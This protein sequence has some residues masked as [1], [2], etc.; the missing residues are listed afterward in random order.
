MIDN[1]VVTLKE[2]VANQSKEK[3]KDAAKICYHTIEETPGEEGSFT[4]KRNL[5]VVCRSKDIAQQGTITPGSFGA[6]GSFR[7]WMT[8]WC[9]VVWSCKWGANGVMP[10]R[11]VVLTTSNIDIPP[12]KA[13]VVQSSL[14]D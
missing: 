7:I 5:D 13:I 11:P 4:L 8:N 6:L 2:A 9:Q 1:A 3:T 12:G 10:L 14:S